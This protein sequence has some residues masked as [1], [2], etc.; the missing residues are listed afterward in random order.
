MK[1]FL[2]PGSVFGGILL[3]AGSCIGAGMLGLPILMGLCGF[4]P[5]LV[6]LISAWGFMTY[7]A[8]LLIEINGWFYEQ[9]NIVSMAGKALGRIGKGISWILYLLLFYSLLVAYI[10]SSGKIFSSIAPSFGMIINIFFIVVL[11]VIVYLGTKPVDLF[12]RFLMFG[13]I[14]SYLVM[15]SFG[16][17]KVNLSLYF[18][19]NMKYFLL[20]LPIL[21]TSFGFHN[22]I[23][24]LTA[25]MKGDLKRTKYAILGGSL[26]ALFIYFFWIV[27][28]LG[29]V[30]VLGKYG[31]MD[32]YMQGT[33]A[34]IAL[35]IFF[36]SIYLS[37]FAQGFAFFAII[38]SFVAQSLSLT[39]FIADGLKV[40]LTKKNNLWLVF[41]VI[42]PPL[43]FAITYPNIFFKA[44]AFA[45]AYCAV[46]LFGILPAL[47]TWIG[48]YKNKETSAY[49]V[50]GGKLALIIIIIF[51]CVI[52]FNEI[53]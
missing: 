26:L 51:F 2:M 22:M 1:N 37:G 31:L 14:I 5:A 17:S 16:I 30:P 48:R 6:L 12:N 21:I 36:Q 45:G 13:L 4:F 10:A 24:S 20:P 9:V 18:H 11:G 23:P 34:S 8:L 41:L 19:V 53:F 15:L 50:K 7:T 49:H 43:F 40:Q 42:F 39:H 29:I 3:I 38:T 27:F 46:I 28:V 25:Y 33:E 32:S 52:I 35:K 44:L 47:M